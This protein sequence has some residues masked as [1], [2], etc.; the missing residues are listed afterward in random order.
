M[1]RTANGFII[2]RK[3]QFIIKKNYKNR[4]ISGNAV[5]A[6]IHVV[7]CGRTV[8]LLVTRRRN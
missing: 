5:M 8:T 3:I 6:V 7:D 4:E 1:Y 2:L